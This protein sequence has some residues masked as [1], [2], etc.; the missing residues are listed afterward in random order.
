MDD[1][2]L[3]QEAQQGQVSA[4]EEL[5]RRWAARLLAYLRSI[6]RDADVAEDLAQDCLLRAYKQLA[7]L[8]DAEKFGSWL[9]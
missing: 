7:S 4:Y 2:Q 1:A 9:R 8:Q 6:V 3:V 5:V